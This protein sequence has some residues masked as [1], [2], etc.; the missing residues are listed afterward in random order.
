MW[1][2]LSPSGRVWGGASPGREAHLSVAGGPGGELEV[3]CLE[4]GLGPLPPAASQQLEGELPR[5]ARRRAELQQYESRYPSPQLLDPERTAAAAAPSR[6]PP[7]MYAPWSGR[8]RGRRGGLGLPGKAW[9]LITTWLLMFSAI[10]FYFSLGQLPQ[11]PWA[12]LR[13][14]A[15]PR[16]VTVLMWWEPFGGKGKSSPAPDCQRLFNLNGCRLLTDRRAYWEANAV[17]F[18]HRDLVRTLDWPPPQIEPGDV[19][20]QDTTTAGAASSGR[21]DRPPGQRWV[22]MNFE[23]PT[24]SP[25]LE[26]L[27]GS[28]FNWTLSYRADS[29]IFVPYGYLYPRS[30]PEEPPSGLI[31]SL[32]RKHK[33]VAWV[34]SHWDEGQ[35]RV[36]YYRELS[37]H[38]EVDVFGQGGPGQPVPDPGLLHTVA[39]YKFY[40]SFENSQ[41]LDY[42]TE[43][44]WRN[45]FLAG[46]VPVVLGPSRANYERFIPR[47]SFIHVDDFPHAAALATYL[48]FLDRNLNEYKRYFEWRRRYAVHILSFWDEPWCRTCQALQRAG[49]QPK[50]INNLAAWFRR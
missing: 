3:W 19:L 16:P 34:V 37:Q 5:R 46:T 41:H 45:A 38:V 30:N 13:P 48:R 43:K 42:I 14:S 23:S 18:H 2:S 21:P 20:D 22:W 10:A 36:R 8:Q 47:N 39:R 44:L 12:Y 1:R 24:N 40:L 11:L 33:L 27:E 25:R 26:S 32:A 7:P 17:L 35:A 15:P 50:K 6:P 49:D 31:S 28:L 9:L 4:S 29:D